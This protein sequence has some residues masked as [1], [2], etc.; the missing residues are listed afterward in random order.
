MVCK[1]GAGEELES[2]VPVVEAMSLLLSGSILKDHTEAVILPEG[3]CV[4]LP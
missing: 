3:V 4:T 2:Y 1:A